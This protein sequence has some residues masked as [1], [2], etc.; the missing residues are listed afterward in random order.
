MGERGSPTRRIR[1]SHSPANRPLFRLRY[2]P[3]S[4]PYALTRV[5]SARNRAATLSLIDAFA[6]DPFLRFLD[7][8]PVDDEPVTAEEMAA[9]AEVQR[10]RAAGV[11]T[12]PFDDIKL[13][14]LA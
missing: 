1:D 2:A 5:D 4:A 9:V 6:T 11:P 3:G 14:Y 10:D 13:E 7:A 8:A 12:I